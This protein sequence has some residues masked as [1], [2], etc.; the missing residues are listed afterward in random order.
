[1]KASG[2]IMIIDLP[3]AIAVLK[4]VAISDF[5]NRISVRRCYRS[6]R[7]PAGVHEFKIKSPRLNLFHKAC[8]QLKN[9]GSH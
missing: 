9:S 7:A 8:R 5:F 1:M 6:G 4:S 2:R 3:R